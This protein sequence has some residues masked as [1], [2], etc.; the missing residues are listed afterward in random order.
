MKQIRSFSTNNSPEEVN[1]VTPCDVPDYYLCSGFPHS[2]SVTT[3]V[4]IT[5]LPQ[6]T[7]HRDLQITETCRSVEGIDFVMF[8]QLMTF[9]VFCR[10]LSLVVVTCNNCLGLL[11]AL[12]NNTSQG[13]CTPHSLNQKVQSSVSWQHLISKSF[14][15]LL[16][17]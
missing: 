17:L 14:L 3:L 11:E 5:S 15:L 9:G 7:D 1:Q 4:L 2:T 16:R 13:L 10:S 8:A 6:C 12:L